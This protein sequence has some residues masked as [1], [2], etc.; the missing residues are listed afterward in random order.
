LTEVTFDHSATT[1]ERDMTLDDLAHCETKIKR[2][3]QELQTIAKDDSGVT[4]LQ[5]IP[6]VGPRTAEAFVAYVDRPQRF[7][8]TKQIGAYF[9]LV[10]SQDQ[11]G[12]SNRLGHIT[13][14]GPSV[15]R[16]LLTEAAWQGV[17]LSPSMQSRYERIRKGDPQNRKIALTAISHY[18][19]R[20]MLAMLKRGETW[21]EA[22]GPPSRKAA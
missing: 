7:R 19:V 11:S 17:R 2:V 22:G 13:R 21:N 6:G 10:P 18:L 12:A 3:E 16:R 9:G 15:M 20:V 1:L 8:R 14:E 4:L 5:T